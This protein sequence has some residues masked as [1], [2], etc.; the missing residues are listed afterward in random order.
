MNIVLT[1]SQYFKLLNEETGGLDSFI[2][3]I[4]NKYPEIEEYRDILKNNI[5]SSGCRNISF[6]PMSMGAGLSLHNRVVISSKL[7]GKFSFTSGRY[8]FN[9][10]GLM[11][12]IFHEI[13]HQHQYNK[14]GKELIY[15]MYTGE[16]ETEGAIKFLRYI[17]NVADQ[18]SLRKCRELQ[19]LGVIPADQKVVG[20]G[21]YDHYTDKMFENYLNMLKDKIQK[22]GLTDPEDISE[23]IYNMIKPKL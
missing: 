4:V 12:V 5:E 2:D 17:E 7:L 14:Y 16:L 10:S 1:E 15:D 11:F 6:E 19:K 13:A 3:Q 20:A 18:F 8:G 22:S 9:V 21:G 23:L